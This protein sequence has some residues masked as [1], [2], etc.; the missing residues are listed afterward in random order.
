MSQEW[1]EDKKK[2]KKKTLQEYKLFSNIQKLHLLGLILELGW[3]KWFYFSWLEKIDFLYYISIWIGEMLVVNIHS[4]FF[5]LTQ[6]KS[7][8]RLCLS[9]EFVW[10]HVVLAII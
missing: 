6:Q 4:I 3:H 2:N 10:V 7:T 1:E 9:F 5:G 8:M